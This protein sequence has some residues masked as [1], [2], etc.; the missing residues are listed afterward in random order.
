MELPYDLIIIIVSDALAFIM[1]ATTIRRSTKDDH[2]RLLGIGLRIAMNIFT[3]FVPSKALKDCSYGEEQLWSVSR[4]VYIPEYIKCSGLSVYTLK[5]HE[6][7]LPTFQWLRA[8]CIVALIASLMM[9]VELFSYWWS[10]EGVGRSQDEDMELAA[11]IEMDVP[12][13]M[14]VE[15][16]SDYMTR[17]IK[18]FR[19]LIVCLAA[20]S[21]ILGMA[22]NTNF[23]FPDKLPLMLT[24]EALTVIFY[25]VFAYGSNEEPQNRSARMFF[26][27]VLTFLM[28]YG[29]QEALRGC[30]Y[31]M[32]RDYDHIGPGIYML[33]EITCRNV[34]RSGNSSSETGATAL[35]M[36]RVFRARCIVPLSACVLMAIEMVIY[37]LSDEAL[38]LPQAGAASAE[39]RNDVE[40]GDRS[41]D[42][43]QKMVLPDPPRAAA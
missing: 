2:Y 29:P 28:I 39:T 6:S 34:D 25:S 3:L 19:Q 15:N 31:E 11:P 13:E 43:P 22:L 1:Y 21:L 38:G 8:L 41:A 16:L 23:V 10:Y 12:K 37:G 32:R 17:P 30:Y 24:S 4:G 18:R 7:L 27:I 36:F 26:R 5:E 33:E 40:L 14:D 20:I 42:E 35:S 9:V